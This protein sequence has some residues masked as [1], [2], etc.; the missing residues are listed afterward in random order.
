MNDECNGFGRKRLWPSVR[1]Y[2]GM[3]LERLEKTT[4]H[5]RILGVPVRVR[6]KRK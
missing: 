3:C 4:K 1:Y 2:L 6:I 5:L